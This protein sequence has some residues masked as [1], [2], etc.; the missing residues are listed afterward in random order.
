MTM[1]SPST[2]KPADYLSAASAA[3]NYTKGKMDIGA[4]NKV[5]PWNFYG[6]VTQGLCA[7][8]AL[9][10]GELQEKIDKEMEGVKKLNPSAGYAEYVDVMASW[11][12]LYGCGN[13][14]PHS[15]IAFVY[16]RDALMVRPLDWMM[17]N[18]FQ[19]AFVIVGRQSDTDSGDY[20]TWNRSSAIC[21]PWRGEAQPV[22][23]YAAMRFHGKKLE[24]LH[25]VAA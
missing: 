16:L 20:R 3:L 7:G 23:P 17:Y 9:G 5:A 18:N 12:K 24:L 4:A 1:G 25:R 2:V 11:A 10:K 19:H 22:V 13:C 14:G 8:S 15:A 6:K 21:D